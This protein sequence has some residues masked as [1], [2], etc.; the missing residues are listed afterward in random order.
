MMDSCPVMRRIY[1]RS[2]ALNL[3]TGERTETGARWVVRPC[4]TPLFG[5]DHERGMC[6]GCAGGWSAPENHPAPPDFDDL[7]PSDRARFRARVFDAPARDLF[8]I[9]GDVDRAALD[10]MIETA[11]RVLYEDENEPPRLRGAFVRDGLN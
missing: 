6:K 4:G 3:A 2:A 1:I 7:P 9:V 5:L 8:D 10:R 11:A